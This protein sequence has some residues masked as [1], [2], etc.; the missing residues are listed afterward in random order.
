[1]SECASRDRRPGAAE[2][3]DATLVESAFLFGRRPAARRV[4]TA[5]IGVE[6]HELSRVAK[7]VG[8]AAVLVTSMMAGAIWIALAGPS[9]V[10]P[11]RG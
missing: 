1:M 2:G 10:L 11:W 4:A 3:T 8:S 9:L 7:D 5:R 6:R